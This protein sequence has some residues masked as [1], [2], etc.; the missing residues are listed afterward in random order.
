MKGG[1]PQDGGREKMV[2]EQLRA[3][4]RGKER[5]EA[6]WPRSFRGVSSHEKLDFCLVQ[7]PGPEGPHETGQTRGS[8][9]AE[10]AFF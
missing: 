4:A 5:G 2:R 10:R 7:L 9:G 8:L 6:G 3:T 1:F